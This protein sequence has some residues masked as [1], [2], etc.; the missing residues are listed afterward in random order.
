MKSVIDCATGEITKVDLD[1]VSKDQQKIDE[2]DFKAA[3][4][5]RKAEAEAKANAKAAILDRIGLTADELQTIL[6]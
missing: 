4:I 6:G 3:E 1:K 5:I 2:A